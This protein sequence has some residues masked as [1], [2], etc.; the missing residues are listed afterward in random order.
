MVRDIVIKREYFMGFSHHAYR[1]IILL[2]RILAQMTFSIGFA[3]VSVSGVIMREGYR[4][5]FS[6]VGFVLG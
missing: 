3:G 1:E 5:T 2:I 6:Q 4:F